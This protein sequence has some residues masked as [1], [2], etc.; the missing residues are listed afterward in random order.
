MGKMGLMFTSLML[1]HPISLRASMIAPS[2]TGVLL[3][4]AFYDAYPS[5]AD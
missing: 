5:A 2:G 4:S 3:F 1:S